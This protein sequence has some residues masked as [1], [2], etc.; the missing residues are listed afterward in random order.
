MIQT[1]WERG[2]LYRCFKTRSD[3]AQSLPAPLTPEAEDAHMAA[4]TP[5]ALRLNTQACHSVITSPLTYEDTGETKTADLTTME[6]V[7]LARKDIG[8][9]YHIAVT[10]DD[11]LEKITHVV[12]GAD[13][14]AQTPY[15]VLLQHLM[16]WPVPIY[17]HHGLLLREDGEKLS[18]RNQDTTIRALREK[19]LT[20]QDVFAMAEA[21]Q[22][23]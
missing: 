10:H 8:L 5:F 21:P 17:H 9:S 6:D 15:H 7:V 3:L 22:A 19:G 12:R 23:S 20:P 16:G 14:T 11:A 18:K 2:L 1:L 4:Q 13:F